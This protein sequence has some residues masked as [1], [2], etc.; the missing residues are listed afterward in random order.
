M[1]DIYTETNFVKRLL[2]NDKMDIK[3]KIIFIKFLEKIRMSAVHPKQHR[4]WK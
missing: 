3:N 4:L 1:Q 2:T